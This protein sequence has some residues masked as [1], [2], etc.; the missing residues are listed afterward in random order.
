VGSV[1]PIALFALGGVLLGGA[2]SLRRQGAPLAAVA[3]LGLLAVLA[4]VAGVLRLVY[5]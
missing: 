2:V 1:L 5:R 3:V 4:V